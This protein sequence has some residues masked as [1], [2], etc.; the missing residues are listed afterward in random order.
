MGQGKVDV[1]AI[2]PFITCLIN[3]FKTMVF[4]DIKRTSLTL[5]KDDSVFGEVSAFIGLA[6]LGS[7]TVVVSFPRDLAR[8]LVA[9]MLHCQEDSLDKQD[10]KDG[11]GEIVNMVAGSAKSAFSDTIYK[12]NI[13]LPIVIE[14]KPTS[15]SCGHKEGVP[16]FAVGFETWDRLPF[17]MEVSI[18]GKPE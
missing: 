3:V 5:K 1:N 18:K 12:F 13:S 11:I 2:N 7:G 8:S 10:I 15:L 14:G 17:I 6:G 4:T 9:R 16:C